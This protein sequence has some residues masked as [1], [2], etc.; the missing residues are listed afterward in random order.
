MP[1]QPNLAIPAFAFLGVANAHLRQF[2]DAGRALSQ[3][4]ALCQNHADSACGEVL[5]AQGLLAS[6]QGDSERASAL[7]RDALQFARSH[8]DSFLEASAAV[9]LGAESIAQGKF[10]QALDESN[11]AYQTAKTIDARVLE[12]IAQGNIGWAAYRLGDSDKAL[13]LFLSAEKRASEVEDFVDQGVWLTDAGYVYMDSRQFNLSNSSFRKALAIEQRM[14]SKENIYNA[15]RGLAR[16]STQQNDP[17]GAATYAGQALDIAKEKEK[18]EAKNPDHPPN[19]VDE[20][21]PTLVLGQVAARRGDPAK[22]QQIFDSVEHDPDCPIF[23]KWEAQHSLARLYEDT[24]QPAVADNEYH[25]ALATFESARTAVTH[26]DFQLSF[27]TNG[28]R[29]YD[30]YIH[31]LIA[32][33]KPDEALR[34]ADHS[35]ARTLAEGLG[36]LGSPKKMESN[37]T[38]PPPLN[39]R[40]ISRRAGATL[41]FYWLGESQSYL[42]AITPQ[43][44]TLFTLPAAPQIDSLILHYRE[45][46]QKSPDILASPDGRALYDAL[47]APAKSLLPDDSR[48]IIIPDGTLNNLNFETLIVS[49]PRPHY[50]IED[51]RLTDVSSLR[52][53]S[54]SLEPSR[55]RSLKRN[56]LLIGNSVAPTAE[57]TTLPRAA[58][59]MADVAKHFKR[60]QILDGQKATPGAYLAAGPEKFSHIHFVAHGIASRLSPLDSAIVLSRPAPDSDAFKLYARDVVQHHLRADLVTISSCFGAGDRAYTGEGLVGLAWAFLRAGAHNVIAGL[61]E[62]S[63][64]STEQLMDAFY[65]QLDRKVPLDDALRNA[66]LSL[67]HDHRYSSPFY[68][69]PFQL[70]TGS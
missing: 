17:A 68:W 13:D 27:L 45:T 41:L 7:F 23:L 64:S 36:L 58:Q 6:E 29:I 3:A 44:A 62:V 35:R 5:Q 15:L 46:I 12:P 56:L 10:D 21:Y 19:H 9:N 33:G 49:G 26:E 42:W 65:D 39:A 32:Q 63:D 52:V 70:Y 2:S 14:E 30:D 55:A 4:A 61:W 16:L 54:A 59:Q 60:E 11:H 51:A 50:W 69:A 57:Y 1:S 24:K 8:S 18:Q 22:A 28:V 66:K 34:W 43:K 38:A 20:L 48:V 25:A 53:L 40:D 31:F 67:L 47:I 37:R